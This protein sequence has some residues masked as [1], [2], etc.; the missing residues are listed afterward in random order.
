MTENKIPTTRNDAKRPTKKTQQETKEY[1]LNKGLF[2]V[3]KI[4]AQV[5]AIS[6]LSNSCK[7]K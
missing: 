1:K 7:L 2:K 5:A 6:R 4:K 3:S